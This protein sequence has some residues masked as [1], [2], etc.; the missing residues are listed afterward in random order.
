MLARLYRGLVNAIQIDRAF[1]AANESRIDDALAIL[2][3]KV[4]AAEDLYYVRL[5]RGQLYERSARIDQAFRE[6]LAAHELIVGSARLIEPEKTYFEAFAAIAAR[7]C[8]AALPRSLSREE[9]D[10][11]RVRFDRVDLRKVPG[12][13]KAYFPLPEHPKWAQG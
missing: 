10:R 5:L 9:E 8:A 13:V 4:R 6:Y 3:G 7:R 2:D 12:R 1:T 11:L